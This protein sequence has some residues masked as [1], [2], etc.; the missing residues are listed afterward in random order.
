MADRKISQFEDFTGYQGADVFYVVASGTT[1]DPDAKNYKV[2]FDTLSTD[3]LNNSPWKTGDGFI[4]TAVPVTALGTSGDLGNYMLDVSGDGRFRQDILI[5]GSINAGGQ[6]KSTGNIE[7]ASDISTSG[8]LIAFTN[9]ISQ[10]D[11]NV[12][13]DIS[14][15]RDI[16]ST[17]DIIAGRNVYI[18]GAGGIYLSGD[19]NGNLVIG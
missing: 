15:G 8:S 2:P 1:E 4:Y 11:L 3:V 10:N 17:E 14:A 9:V 7:S 18:D 6:I 13:R 12:G 5:S 19:N 16:E